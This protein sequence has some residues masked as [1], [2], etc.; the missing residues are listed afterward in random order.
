MKPYQTRRSDVR[1]L[2]PVYRSSVKMTKQ[3]QVVVLI[4]VFKSSKYS[5]MMY[6]DYSVSSLTLC[7]AAFSLTKL[8]TRSEH[9]L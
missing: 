8:L 7:H 9:W 3:P 1:Y 6:P 4:N 5:W 2:A